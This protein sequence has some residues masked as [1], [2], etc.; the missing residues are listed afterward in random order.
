[1]ARE[2]LNRDSNQHPQFSI[3]T[4]SDSNEKSLLLSSDNN[5]YDN[6]TNNVD[7]DDDS[8]EG[9]NH[10]N[11]PI[12][13]V[14]KCFTRNW[15]R[16]LIII[17][18]AE[19][20]VLYHYGIFR[21]SKLFKFVPGGLPG[22][23]TKTQVLGFQIHTGGGPAV[24][25]STSSIWSST[26][27]GI[28]SNSTNQ[29]VSATEINPECIQYGKRFGLLGGIDNVDEPEFDCYIGL[30]DPYQDVTK[31]LQVMIDAVEAAYNVAESDPS[32]L[33]IFVAPEFFFR[34]LD[35]AYKWDTEHDNECGPICKILE[36]LENIVADKRFEDWFFL[37]GSIIAYEDIP[38]KKDDS[39]PK[40]KA[41][42]DDDNSDDDDGFQFLFY[43][44]APIYR[45]YDPEKT[46]YYGKR[47][48]L[49]KRYTSTLDFLTPQRAVNVSF[50]QEVLGHN[51]TLPIVNETI[52]NPYDV[53][54]SKYDIQVYDNYRNEIES[55]GYTLIDYDWI[56][57][58]DITMSIEICFDHFHARA[59]QTYM[60]DSISGKRIRIPKFSSSDDTLTFVPIPD[61]QAQIQLVSS[62]GMTINPDAMTLM[63]GAT[64]YLQDGLYDDTADI[65]W[66]DYDTRIDETVGGSEAIQRTVSI[67]STDIDYHYEQ[68][69]VVEKV[70]VYETGTSTNTTSQN[71][72]GHPRTK[73]WQSAVDGVFSK[74][75]YEPMI[76][77]WDSQ[78]VITE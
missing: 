19:A 56:I 6:N 20:I 54:E 36:G 37:F 42:G 74:A 60:A 9:L 29:T 34:G 40:N 76:V 17:I 52:D 39:Q 51:L 66:K 13:G 45:G 67:S 23:Y 38:Q 14:Y 30:Q 69:E 48:L 63:D 5:K 58:D 4:K 2:N 33:K 53:W 64:I 70:S 7:Y 73:Y 43:N 41:E 68:I 72:Q 55:L 35:G 59:L 3:M 49:P 16:I 8:E 22:P 25:N 10:S 44:F 12:R 78:D 47:F 61:H 50:T 62:S 28:S 27:A 31:R 18:I 75:L 1:L 57:M 46:N 71:K 77:I 65:E 11:N 32:T 24:I 15:R 21:K 26:K